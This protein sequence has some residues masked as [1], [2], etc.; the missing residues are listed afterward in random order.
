[1]TIFLCTKMY[2]IKN[3]EGAINCSNLKENKI[4][5]SKEA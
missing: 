5:S 1:M 3:K 4:S 2:A